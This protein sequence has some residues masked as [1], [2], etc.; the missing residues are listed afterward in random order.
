MRIKP[1][2]GSVVGKTDANHWGQVLLTPTIYGVVE[3]EDTSGAARVCG[4]RVL[5]SV[6][7]AAGE[8]T[9]LADLTAI[10]QSARE[11]TVKTLILLAPVGTVIYIASAGGGTVFLKRK[12]QLATLIEHEGAIS[13]ELKEGDTLLLASLGFTAVLSREAL[14]QTFDHLP[15]ADIAEKLT[16]MLHEKTDTTGGAALIL[17]ATGVEEEEPA[18]FAQE[19]ASIAQPAAAVSFRSRMSRVGV[20][21]FVSG[22]RSKKTIKLAA[23]GLIISVFAISILLGVMRE[24]GKGNS[25]AVIQAMTQAQYA[26]DEGVALLELNPVK[27]RERLAEAKAMI[28]PLISSVSAK[29]REGRQVAA[30][31]QK[32]MDN[33]TAAMQVTT[34]EPELFFDVSLLKKSGVA[35]RIALRGETLGILDAATST[36]YT[37]AVPSKSGEIVAGGASLGRASDVSL[38]GDNLYV[39]T[40]TGIQLVS[41]ADRKVT[42]DVIKKSTEWG[43]VASLVSF[44]GNLYVLDTQ[45][46]RIWKY[47]ATDKAT[48]AGGQ[49]F[50]ELREYLNPDTLPDLSRATGMAI[51]GSVWMGTSD[52]KILRF[53]QGKE[54]TFV[55][56]GIEPGFGSY[57]VVAA[58]DE[59][60]H[61]YVLDRDNKR[62]V[63][64]DPDGTYIAQYSWQGNITPDQLAVSEKLKKI[65]LLAE[66]KIYAINLK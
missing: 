53:T 25:Q 24:R 48:P 7:Q 12:D 39:L 21:E 6:T 11:P 28:E 47:V 26:F 63:V 33:L 31:Y 54:N 61:V 62:V 3:V 45:K 66:G 27:G 18:E 60:E 59:S 32:I 40:D 64:L 65:F 10:I 51:D 16:L 36:V 19:I 15:P 41:S 42:P 46:S 14:A 37:V 9:S 13:G 30:L 8:V 1:S 22:L 23:T 34:A 56:K 2:T 43:S 49:G 29:T 52:G 50:S 4:L 17:Q 44:G 58:I 5:G 20:K 57:V 38:H 55:P 35:S